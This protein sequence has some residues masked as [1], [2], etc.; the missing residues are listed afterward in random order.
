[1]NDQTDSE[2]L[3]ADALRAQA[4]RAPLS[5]PASRPPFAG[6]PAGN[7]HS[8]AL[9]GPAAQPIQAPIPAPPQSQPIHAD[10][11]A[12]LSGSDPNLL[13]GHQHPPMPTAIQPPVRVGPPQRR[14]SGPPAVWLIL[15]LALLLGLAAG[16][17]AGVFTLF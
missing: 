4:V 7:Q 11:F 9:P 3:L 15:L 2:K 10:P 6:P 1:M 12:L 17:V 8:A 14:R 16:A 13:S 5:E